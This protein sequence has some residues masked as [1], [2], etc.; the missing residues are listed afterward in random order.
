MFRLPNYSA[1]AGES[2]ALSPYYNPPKSDVYAN[3]ENPFD[4]LRRASLTS[5]EIFSDEAISP[6]STWS[7]S[8][9][10][11]S[12]LS[13]FSP[14]T[15]VSQSTAPIRRR[16][17]KAKT[18]PTYERV[19]QVTGPTSAGL[20]RIFPELISLDEQAKTF[21]LQANFVYATQSRNLP[22]YQIQPIFGCDGRPLSLN[23][24]RIQPHETR[25]CSVPAMYAAQGRRIRYNE[26]STLYSISEYETKGRNA[27][28]LR[29]SIQLTTGKTLWGGQ[30]TRI[31]HVTRC[32]AQHHA[33]DYRGSCEPEKHLLFC[34][35]KGVWEDAQGA[36]VGREGNGRLSSWVREGF[37]RWKGSVSESESRVLEMVDGVKREQSKSDLLVACWVMRLWMAGECTWEED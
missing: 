16:I 34:V 10:P 22:Q 30:W 17:V 20:P 4:A 3:E 21:R 29:G 26:E 25:S 14:A 19:P 11:N 31:W 33:C 18:F 15:S 7:S 32:K 1:P 6:T 27:S 8:A 28:A 37:A 13:P 23:I 35:K 2:I 24:R 12:S 9:R 5:E 36:I